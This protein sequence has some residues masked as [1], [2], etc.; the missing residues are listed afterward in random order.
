[1]N[2]ANIVTNGMIG[3]KNDML[4][5]DTRKSRPALL[6]RCRREFQS[7]INELRGKENISRYIERL[8]R[9]DGAKHGVYVPIRLIPKSL[10]K[11]AEL[12]L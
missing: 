1:M 11:R 2:N 6:F 7:A 8:I 5:D 12:G 10:K 9:E 4:I 3:M